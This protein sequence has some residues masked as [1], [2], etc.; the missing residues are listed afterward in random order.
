VS[1]PSVWSTAPKRL[2]LPSDTARTGIW[3][4]ECQELL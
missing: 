3:S 2:R 4:V 1:P